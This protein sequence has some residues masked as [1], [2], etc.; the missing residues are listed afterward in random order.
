MA[1]PSL[2][3]AAD[4][5]ALIPRDDAR[6]YSNIAVPD[7]PIASAGARPRGASTAAVSDSAADSPAG[8]GGT[9]GAAGDAG[10]G[11]LPN[12]LER[13]A[14]AIRAGPS[15]LLVH[16]LDPARSRPT[17]CRCG[18]PHEPPWSGC[19]DG[20]GLILPFCLAIPGADGAAQAPPAA[21]GGRAPD[22]AAGREAVER[23][24]SPHV[25]DPEPALP[26]SPAVMA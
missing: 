15:P 21:Q 6:D 8:P 4:L 12:T 14:A 24:R 3:L 7:D 23:V 19:C 10:R 25:G 16:P 13:A 11:P 17:H 20:C 26:A 9:P 22:P 2:P 18:W 5:L 1:C